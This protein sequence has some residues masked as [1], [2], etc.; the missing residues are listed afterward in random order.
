M[1]KEYFGNYE[2]DIS[3]IFHL[4]DHGIPVFLFRPE[5]VP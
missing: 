3:D 1:I 5:D 4:P 2:T